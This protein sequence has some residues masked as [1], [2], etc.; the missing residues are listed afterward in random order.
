M[1]VGINST[2]DL[3]QA[4]KDDRVAPQYYICLTLFYVHMQET[5]NVT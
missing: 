3:N 1:K 5:N 4:T 2:G